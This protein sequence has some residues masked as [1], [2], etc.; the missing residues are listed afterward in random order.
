MKD[1]TQIIGANAERARRHN[2]QMALD[3]IRKAGVLG[4]AE[5]ARESGLSTQAVSNI[6]ADLLS[7]DLIVER[8]RKEGVRGQPPVL[9]GLNPKGGYALGIEIRPDAVFAAVL[10]FCGTTISSLRMPLAKADLSIITD[11]VLSAKEAVLRKAKLKTSAVLGVGI[12][13]PGP[14]GST[15][16]SGTG[17]ELAVFDNIRPTEWFE[18]KLGL[19]VVVENDANAAAI[20]ERLSGVAH[21][22]DT[23][24][25]LYFGSG[26]GLGVVQDGRIVQGAFNNAGEIG[27]ILI[28]TSNRPAPLEMVLSRLSAQRY[29]ECAGVKAETADALGQHFQAGTP[30]LM[31]WLD[32]ATEGL[33]YA[34]S[35]VENMLD[36]ETIVLGGAM[37]QSI[38]DHMIDNLALPTRTPSVR[39]DRT[40]PRV[41][42]GA[43]GSMTGTLG[44]AALVLNRAFT[45]Q[46]ATTT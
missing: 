33:S 41:Q 32:E 15:G 21:G 38:L 5:I 7:D 17:S 1:S 26:L 29:M 28:P 23:F 39:P 2:R 27:H 30:D 35:I 43:S 40:L 45:P 12:V 3:R 4:R 6:I 34:V 20:A 10:D 24:A 8:G 25:L 11:A 19:P 44:A 42:R 16:L 46:I 13:M 31:T 9:Y 18:E 37:P 36:P 14:F 22:I